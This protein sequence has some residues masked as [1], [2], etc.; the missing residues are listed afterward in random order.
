MQPVAT[1]SSTPAMPSTTCDGHRWLL[2][3]ISTAGGPAGLRVHV[4]RKL[5]SLGALYLHQSVCLLPAREPLLRH[6]R[7]LLDRVHREGGSGRYLTLSFDG[8]GEQQIVAEFRAARDEEYSE[9]L[10][11]IPEFLE[12]LARERARGRAS[13]AEVE[14]S[15]AD[16]ERFRSWLTKIEARDYFVAPRRDEARAAVARCAEELAAFEA[17]ALAAEAPEVGS[18]ADTGDCGV[19]L[20][21][22]ANGE[23]FP[24]RD[25]RAVD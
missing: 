20:D 22:A 24:G 17:E 8:H 13:Y 11:R 19:H 9:V 18:S 7:R 14:E 15:E 2:L 10:D 25:L 5:R 21:D 3:T 23:L 6:V 12:E 1:S 16:L 4:W